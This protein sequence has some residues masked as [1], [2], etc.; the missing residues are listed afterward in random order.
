[1]ESEFSWSYSQKLA[2]GPCIESRDCIPQLHI[3]Y[4]HDVSE[5]YPPVNDWFLT[6]VC[7]SWNFMHMSLYYPCFSPPLALISFGGVLPDWCLVEYLRGWGQVSRNIGGRIWAAPRR[8]PRY[9]CSH[10]NW[11]N[12]RGLLF[13][14]VCRALELVVVICKDAKPV[15]G[16]LY[17]SYTGYTQNNGAV[18]IVNT[19]TTA[20]FFYV[21][22]VLM[23]V[24][25]D[26]LLQLHLSF[27]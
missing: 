23:I 5:C 15:Q 6:F 19:I 2:I 7:S 14:Q 21:C 27:M 1:M 22:P 8:C 4:R 16:L 17:L 25:A 10:C 9:K 13:V 26:K 20:P 12:Y 11:S 18:L 3:V 24:R